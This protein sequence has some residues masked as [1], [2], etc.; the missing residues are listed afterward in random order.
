MELS[1]LEQSLKSLND[2]RKDPTADDKELLKLVDEFK[3][4]SRGLDLD[5]TDKKEI[6][7]FSKRFKEFMIDLNKYLKKVGPLEIEGWA[8]R[9]GLDLYGSGE[10]SDECQELI[11][12]VFKIYSTWC[13]EVRD[14]LGSKGFEE[15]FA[16]EEYWH[17]EETGDTVC[18]SDMGTYCAY[19]TLSKVIEKFNKE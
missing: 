14:W 8:D 4:F 13:D 15:D 17:N 9:V 19:E 18:V 1:K 10:V 5:K 6:E 3:D 11:D 16:P 12:N 2:S 7:K